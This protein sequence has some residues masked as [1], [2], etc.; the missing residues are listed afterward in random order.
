MSSL[1]Y[2]LD[3]FPDQRALLE[4]D[5]SIAASAMPEI[6]RY[7]SPVVHMRRTAT[8]D[9]ELMG[10]QIAAGDKVVMWY[11]SANFDE[12]VF[13]DPEVLDLKRGNA[14]KHL[15]FGYGIH[16]CVGARLAELQ[17][18]VLIE[19]MAAR[20]LRV[21]VTGQVRRGGGAF[22]HAFRKLEVQVERY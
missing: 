3:R 10:Q 4:A 14:R 9:T 22:M 17:L 15:A 5:P 13:D 7:A 19:E 6:I 16:R 2:A 18:R 20:R 1:A 21:H 12:T 8:R 11:L